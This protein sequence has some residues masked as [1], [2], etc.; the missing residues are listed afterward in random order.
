M[1]TDAGVTVLE[2]L[3]I[4]GTYVILTVLVWGLFA[5]DRGPFQDEL[6]VLNH[7]QSQSGWW[8]QSFYQIASPTR[9]FGATTFALAHWSG[10]PFVTL[11]IMYGLVWLS[12]GVLVHALVRQ[13]LP[14]DRWVAFVAGALALTI[15]GDFATNYLQSLHIALSAALGF[16]AVLSLVRW[17]R[18]GALVWLA[19]AAVCQW[20]SVFTYD[21]AI[22][23]LLL[24][25]GLLWVLDRGRLSRRLVTGSIVWYALLMP[26]LILFLRFILDPSGYAGISLVP[27]TPRGTLKRTAELLLNNFTPWTPAFARSQWFDAPAALLPIPLRVILAAFGAVV[28]AA[29]AAWLRGRDTDR[30]EKASSIAII[31]GTCVLLAL[32]A[33]ASYAR[34]RF[35]EFLFRTQFVS[36]LW[37]AIAIAGIARSLGLYWP[38]ARFLSILVPT[39]FVGL[40]IYGGLER[41][42]YYLGYWRRHQSELQSIVQQVPGLRPDSRVVLHVASDAP[43]LAT[44]PFYKA[45][46]SLAYLYGDSGLTTR[47]VLWDNSCSVTSNALVCGGKGSAACL[48]SGLCERETLP[49]AKTVFLDYSIQDNRYVLD[50]TLPA[51]IQGDRSLRRDDYRP[52][53]LI[54]NQPL[55]ARTKTWLYGP[56]FLGSLFPGVPPIDGDADAR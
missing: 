50:E 19:L 38:S 2:R 17:W 40:G 47:V 31:V 10:V 21:S 9:I 12:S 52:H 30:S 39:V 55:P 43:Y 35:S 26:Y 6:P 51:W 42:D 53:E 15:T 32:A 29:V 8:A 23:T 24:A 36:R 45:F 33:S 37:S 46:G 25:P 41:Q 11:Q 56:S 16:A 13:M 34:V 3:A 48:Q 54:V 4:V 18:H 28:F 20:A 22:S 14:N 7:I 44:A 5:L 1:S 49:F 27:M